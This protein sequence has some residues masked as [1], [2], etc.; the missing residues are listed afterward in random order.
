VKE[1]AIPWL[2]VEIVGRAEGPTGGKKLTVTTHIQRVNTDGGAAPATGCAMAADVG[3]KA[4][5]PYTAD[6]FFFSRHTDEGEG[7]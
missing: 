6:Y 2:L 4:F 1:G 5:M 3:N 7:K